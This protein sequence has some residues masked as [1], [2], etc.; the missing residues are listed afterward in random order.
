MWDFNGAGVKQ[1]RKNRLLLEAAWPEYKA[2]EPVW[3]YSLIEKLH[4]EEEIVKMI[5]IIHPGTFAKQKCC[6]L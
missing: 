1:A 5:E 6:N 2:V 4:K 3:E